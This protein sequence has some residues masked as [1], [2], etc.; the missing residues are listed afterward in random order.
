MREALSELGEVEY[1]II[2]LQKQ[3]KYLLLR[4]K[5]LIQLIEKT[6]DT[7]NS[8]GLDPEGEPTEISTTS[9]GRISNR[10]T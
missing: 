10:E 4:K 3:L 1:S 2:Q 6:Y 5:F 7:S 8:E 9:P